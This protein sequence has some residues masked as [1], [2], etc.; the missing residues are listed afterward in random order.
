LRQVDNSLNF[1][2]ASKEIFMDCKKSSMYGSNC[3]F[4]GTRDNKICNCILNG[5]PCLKFLDGTDILELIREILNMVV[6]VHGEYIN[7]IIEDIRTKK[8]S[9]INLLSKIYNIIN[10]NDCDI[11]NR[12]LA[13]EKFEE[14]RELYNKTIIDKNGG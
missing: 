6:I 13:K 8:I 3:A 4:M 11:T 10:D 12:V 1:F 7:N 5:Q 9:M 14:L 2:V